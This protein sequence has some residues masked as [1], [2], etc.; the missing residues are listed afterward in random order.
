MGTWVLGTLD[1]E[2]VDA[3][4]TIHRHVTPYLAR[5]EAPKLV[6]SPSVGTMAGNKQIEIIKSKINNLRAVLISSKYHMI[7]YIRPVLCARQV[8]YF[9]AGVDGTACE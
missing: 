8:L 7:H 5:T 4:P 3:M 9:A 1:L 2:I 6:L